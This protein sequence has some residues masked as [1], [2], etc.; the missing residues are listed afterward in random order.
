MDDLEGE[1]EFATIARQHWLQSSKKPAT[2]KVRNE[3]VKTEI[4]DAL[5]K[6]N[7]ALKSLSVLEGLQFLERCFDLQSGLL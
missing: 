5:E 2:V 3:V 7:F 6:E 1:S 4:W